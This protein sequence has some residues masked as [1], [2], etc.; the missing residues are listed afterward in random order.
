MIESE[1]CPQRRSPFLKAIA[2][3]ASTVLAGN[4]GYAAGP[5]PKGFVYLRDVDLS[6]R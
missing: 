4:V 6:I 2:Y 3:V 5:L 1:I